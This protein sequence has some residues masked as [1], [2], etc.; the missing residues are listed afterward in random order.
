MEAS[1]LRRITR[2]RYYVRY[3]LFELGLCA[4]WRRGTYR[5]VSKARYIKVNKYENN[6]EHEN[7]GFRHTLKPL[8]AIFNPVANAISQNLTSC[9]NDQVDASS[10]FSVQ[11]GFYSTRWDSW[12]ETTDLANGLCLYCSA[13]IC[14]LI[15]TNV[16]QQL[17][18][19]RLE[20]A[21]GYDLWASITLKSIQAWWGNRYM[22]WV[23][24]TSSHCILFE[25]FSASS[26]EGELYYATNC[27]LHKH[28]RM[29]LRCLQQHA[30]R[31]PGSTTSNSH[32]FR[33]QK[34][35]DYHCLSCLHV[36]ANVRQ[37]IK[38]QS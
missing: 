25:N 17:R 30:S 6:F 34:S 22:N 11:Q 35:A 38:S 26:W 18:P 13:H 31:I 36:L 14:A 10:R 8:R 27:R 21:T 3:Q 12:T 5:H 32:I 7:E 4:P 1:K 20:L 9:G 23:V 15:L 37:H 2:D 16:F 33:E 24:P 28:S 19:L 29:A